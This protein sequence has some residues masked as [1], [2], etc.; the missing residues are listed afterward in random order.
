MHQSKTL[1]SNTFRRRFG[2]NFLLVAAC[3][4]ILQS[5]FLEIDKSRAALFL[6]VLFTFS[7][8]LA[9]TISF[10]ESRNSPDE[11]TKPPIHRRVLYWISTVGLIAYFASYFAAT[12][13]QIEIA[14]MRVT[15]SLIIM[16]VA[17]ALD[18]AASR[19]GA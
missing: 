15:P 12:V 17:L 8:I 5:T 7:L 1:F 9:G 16:I 6:V 4:L 2:H 13:H 10:L 18:L 3:G 11:D 19:K 14:K